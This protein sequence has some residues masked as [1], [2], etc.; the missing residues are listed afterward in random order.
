MHSSRMRTYRTLY[1]INKSTT[2]GGLQES[3]NNYGIILKS[4]YS[5]IIT[6]K[7]SEKY[8]SMNFLHCPNP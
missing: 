6:D 7:E 3:G 8:A 5:S 4:V 1:R 2:G